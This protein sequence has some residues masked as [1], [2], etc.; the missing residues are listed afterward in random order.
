MWSGTRLSCFSATAAEYPIDSVAALIG[1]SASRSVS[2]DARGAWEPRGHS[3]SPA[4]RIST[5]KRVRRLGLTQPF[6]PR[7]AVR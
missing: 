5:V 1:N 3:R 7:A 2:Q 4:R 6:G